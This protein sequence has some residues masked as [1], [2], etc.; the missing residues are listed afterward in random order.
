[1][2]EVLCR[3]HP[4]EP[5]RAWDRGRGLCLLCCLDE[6]PRLHPFPR[7]GW[8]VLAVPMW[9]WETAVLARMWVGAAMAHSCCQSPYES[10][11]VVTLKARQVS[12]EPGAIPVP[13][14]MLA[15]RRHAHE[16]AAVAGR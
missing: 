2:A 11:E 10:D 8:D 7:L 9:L 1:V 4:D 14:W 5:M 3:N 13:C 15:L 12:F 6:D 16:A